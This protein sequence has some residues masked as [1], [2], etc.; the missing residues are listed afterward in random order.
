MSPGEPAAD[1]L[2]TPAIGLDKRSYRRDLSRAFWFALVN[3][4]A[5]IRLLPWQLRRALDQIDAGGHPFAVSYPLARWGFGGALVLEIDPNRLETWLVSFASRGGRLVAL[6]DFFVGSGDW[7]PL[8]HD[9]T[10][11]PL[12]NEIV[13]LIAHDLQIEDCPVY[14]RAIERLATEG[15][16][17]RN[18]VRLTRREDILTY[19]Q[20]YVDLIDSVKTHGLMRRAERPDPGTLGGLRSRYHQMI[21]T[22]VGVAV[23]R[24]GRLHRFRGG[25]HRTAIAKCLGLERMPV[26]VKLVHA[27]WLKGVMAETGLPPHQAVIAGLE[28]LQN[29]STLASGVPG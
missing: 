27:D 3:T 19:F 25:F 20:H 23:D 16:F 8:L 26:A 21:E 2:L 22:D 15:P 10:V 6:R 12:H 7:S 4:P 18:Y 29:R 17:V 5:G 9:I 11:S 24:D 14:H 13:D 1:T 28:S